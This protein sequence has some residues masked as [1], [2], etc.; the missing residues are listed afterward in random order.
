MTRRF[1]PASNVCFLAVLVAVLNG[2]FL[3]SLGVAVPA[4]RT[5]RGAE[6]EVFG[7]MLASYVAVLRTV[8]QI[9]IV[10]YLLAVGQLVILLIRGQAYEPTLPKS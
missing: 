7:A 9:S 4:A 10:V 3:P 2:A 5:G 1:L 8:Q 6:Y